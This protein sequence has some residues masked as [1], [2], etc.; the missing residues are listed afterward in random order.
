MCSIA[1]DVACVCHHMFETR[2]DEGTD[3][4][5]ACSGQVRQV[6]ITRTSVKDPGRYSFP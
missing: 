5:F 1:H 6:A 2:V 3:S 4:S